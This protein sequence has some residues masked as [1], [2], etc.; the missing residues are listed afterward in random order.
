MDTDLLKWLGSLGV[1]GVLAGGMFWVYRKDS[2]YMQER[3]LAMAN[4]LLDT[5]EDVH[6]SMTQVSTLLHRLAQRLD[7][8]EGK[9]DG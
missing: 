1:G 9:S 3:L 4:R 8:K 5:L 7:T 2:L 6:R